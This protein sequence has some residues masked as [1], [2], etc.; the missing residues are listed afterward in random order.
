MNKKLMNIYGWVFVRP[1]RW[2]FWK[3]IARGSFGLRWLPKYDEC[4][5]RWELP[6]LHWWILYWTV[7]KL[8]KW[9]EWDG[10]RPFCQWQENGWIK[11]RPLIAK[12]IQRIGETTAGYAISGGECYHCAS[13]KGCR[14]TLSSDET[15]T[16]FILER[17][18]TVGTEDGTDYRF[19]GTTICPVCGYKHYYED[20]SL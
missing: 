19:C 14:V 17:S 10:W 3:M 15:G 20:G 2:F 13:K 6:N 5:E 9:M 11:H 18:W 7:F 12:I 8:C 16:E 4:W 1:R